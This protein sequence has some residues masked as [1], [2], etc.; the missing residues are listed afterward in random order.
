MT[1]E[2]ATLIAPATYRRS[3]D[4]DDTAPRNEYHNG[5]VHPMPGASPAHHLI[6]SNLSGLLH[7][8][9]DHTDDY[10]IFGSDMRVGTPNEQSYTYPDLVLV[11]GAPDYHP[12]WRTATLRN[13]LLIIEVLSATTQHYDRGEKFVR[14]Q[15]IPSLREYLLIEQRAVSLTQWSHTPDGWHATRYTRPEQQVALASIPLH[16]PLAHIYRRVAL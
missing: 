12:D 7:Q 10:Y 8:A 4:R 9:L 5:E 11:A 16:L 3:E 13:P 6:V 14:Y 1:S 2:T 15:T